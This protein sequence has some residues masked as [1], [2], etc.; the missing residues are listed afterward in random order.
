MEI[1][2]IQKCSKI[3]S[4]QIIV[5]LFPFWLVLLFY[6]SSY[7]YFNCFYKAKSVQ[8]HLMTSLLH[9][10]TVFFLFLKKVIVLIY[11]MG[12][13]SRNCSTLHLALAVSAWFQTNTAMSPC[14][15]PRAVER[16]FVS[17]SLFNISSNYAVGL[18]KDVTKQI[19]LL[20]IPWTITATTTLTAL[21]KAWKLEWCCTGPGCS[22]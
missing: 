16:Y 9:W 14:F 19:L 3:C 17:K 15:S 6:L 18:R 7:V 13:N 8:L 2:G 1:K 10:F 5:T 11:T 12:L 4:P 21:L 20:D 22:R